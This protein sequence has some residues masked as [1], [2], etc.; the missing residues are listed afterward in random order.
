MSRKYA[1]Y[2]DDYTAY[3][4]NPYNKATHF[5]GIP[6]IVFAIIGLLQPLHLVD[7]MGLRLDVALVIIAPVLVFYLTLARVTGIAMALVFALMY[8]GGWYVSNTVLWVL[9]V[10]G[11]IFQFI[12]HKWEGKSPAFFTNVVHLLVGPMWIL[13]DILLKLRLPAYR[14]GTA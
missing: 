6:M 13:N 2:I 12:G 11:W 3:H 10:A 5:L 7:V 9:F 8:W 4:R 14:P 1:A